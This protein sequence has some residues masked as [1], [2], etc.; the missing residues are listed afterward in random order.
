MRERTAMFLP[1]D[2]WYLALCQLA[3]RRLAPPGD[4]D[5]ACDACSSLRSAVD[6]PASDASLHRS[7]G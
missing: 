7:D 1:F 4:V 6:K 5:A 3:G 2:G